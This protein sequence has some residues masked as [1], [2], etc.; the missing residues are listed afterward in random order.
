MYVYIYRQIY[1]HICVY[2]YIYI[3]ITLKPQTGRRPWRCSLRLPIWCR[4][5][6]RRSPKPGSGDCRAG[7]TTPTL[8][9]QPSNRPSTV[10]VLSQIAEQLG[11]SEDEFNGPPLNPE[12]STL[13]PQPSTLNPQPSTLNPQP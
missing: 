7:S 2:I 13:N 10:A 4:R 8:N 9:S 6:F 5:R 11:I 3:Y 12:P 1:I